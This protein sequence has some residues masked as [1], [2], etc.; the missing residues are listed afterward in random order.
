MTR[1]PVNSSNISE[2]G[3][4]PGSSTLEVVFTNGRVYQYFDVPE[5]L[6]D[7]LIQ[8]SSA[9]QY[10]NREIRGFYRFARV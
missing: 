10:F 4:D 8:S 7:D 3:Y 1:T 2:V 6:Y 5:R 9:G